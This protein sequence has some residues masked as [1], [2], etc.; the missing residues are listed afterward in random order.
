MVT[1]DL[2]VIG[3]G[4]GGLA[5]AVTAAQAGLHVVLVDE[6]PVP[7]GQYLGSILSPATATEREGQALIER[8]RHST[9]DLRSE[10]LIWDVSSG[11]R[12]SL[13]GPQG[14]QTLEPRA[15]IVAGGG[16]EL[17]LPFPGWTLPGVMTAGAAQLLIKKYSVLPGQRVLLAGSGPLL[18]PVAHSL[19]QGGANVISILE[20]TN[21]LAWLRRAPALV[22]M[23]GNWDRLTEGWHYLN[24]LGRA[25]VPYRFG[26]TVVRALGTDRVEAAVVA[27]LDA[28]GRPLVATEKTIPI[29]VLCV[30]FGLLPN[31][32][33]TQVSG[34][35][36]RYDLAAGG[37]VPVL[38]E[39]LQTTVA[40]LFAVGETGGIGGAA[41]A[42]TEGR[43]AALQVAAR[44][45]R[46][47]D[48]RLAAQLRRLARRRSSQRRFGRLINTLFAPQPG[49]DG[50]ATDETPICRCEEVLA[51][52]LRA[53]V[54]QGVRRLDELKTRTRVGQGNCQG[55]TCGP[56]A[57]RILAAETGLSLADIA[58]FHVRPP[59]KPV[60]LG[61]LAQEMRS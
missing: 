16:R 21:P 57:A 7:G 6:R 8:L 9:V 41:V 53:A 5:A 61:V 28:A 45:G 35:A 10:T 17:V 39:Q 13:Y 36:H 14:L 58:G 18:L 25:R 59:V 31:I 3:A 44:L 52:E 48:R 33:L 29:D 12:L 56:L 23:I 11:L 50:L 27:R 46:G 34:C 30:G 51:G 42:M 55:R 49:L 43:L 40:G 54:G 2:V 24:G 32:E 1:T 20:A 47:D 60:P 38:D 4:P 15:V 22:Q 26:W 19:A 37:W